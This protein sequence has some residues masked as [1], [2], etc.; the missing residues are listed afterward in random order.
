[1]ITASVMKV[2]R[3]LGY[4]PVV[5]GVLIM[6][7][8]GLKNSDLESLRILV[9]MPFGLTPLFIFILSIKTSISF[10]V[11]GVKNILFFFMDPKYDKCMFLDFKMFVL[12][13]PAI[14]VK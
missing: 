13:S 2:L 4:I 10:G 3:A 7:R 1:M 14:I 5:K 8:R 9:G 12:S 6:S 11:V